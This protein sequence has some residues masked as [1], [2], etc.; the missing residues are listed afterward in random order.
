MR[1]PD[2]CNRT[3]T[4]FGE[5]SENAQIVF[6][7]EGPGQ[8]EDEEGR[9]FVGRAGELLTNMIIACGWQREDVY[10]CNI[11]KCRPPN[12]RVPTPQE[13]Q[14][15]ENYLKLQLKI[16]NPKFIICLGATAAKYLLKLESPIGRLRG[17][18][19]KYTD[20]H[21]NADCIATYHPAY[22]LRNPSAKGLVAEDLSLV[23]N[24][25]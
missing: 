10:I 22:L 24:K 9:P 15:C 19:F 25:L 18:W 4:V 13:A 1:C 17:Q 2:L 3:N 5:G 12:N 14:N 6:V 16:I 8:T 11:V 7:G 21:V 23:V 20:A